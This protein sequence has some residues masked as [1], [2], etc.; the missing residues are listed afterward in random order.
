M[1]PKIKKRG[2]QRVNEA[3]HGSWRR[4]V[5][6]SKAAIAARSKLVGLL[7]EGLSKEYWLLLESYRYLMDKI[8]VDWF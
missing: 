2:K 3:Y 7:I 8:L 1:I 6:M 5:A 4:S